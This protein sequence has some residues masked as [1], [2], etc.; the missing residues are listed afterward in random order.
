MVDAL[1]N[2]DLQRLGPALRDLPLATAGS[3]VAIALP[4]NFGLAPSRRADAVP[5]AAGLQAVLSGSC[6]AAT[7][8]Q[9]QHFIASAASALALDPLRLAA[10]RD[11]VVAAA[12]DWASYRL[13]AGPV[14]VYSPGD[15][16]G[17]A[18][19][20]VQLGAQQAGALIESALAVIAR[21]LVA[22]GVRQLVVAGGETAGACVQ[23]LGVAQ[24]HL[25]PQIDPGVPWC[26]AQTQVQ[27]SVPAG[28]AD[29]AHSTAA[30]SGIARSPATVHLG[31][32]SG[33]F[34]GDDF[35]TRAFALLR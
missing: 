5:A 12:L 19:Q 20:Q 23:A 1:S 30:E 14:L 26:H 31:L 17:V 11:A 33:N 4:A 8:R 16:Q 32:K 7:Q 10:G 9:L 2:D 18:A 28:R 15:A 6:S 24:L 35:F 13:E 29:R 3:G 27:V 25:G 34:G 21:G 22:L